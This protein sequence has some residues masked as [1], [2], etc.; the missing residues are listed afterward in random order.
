MEVLAL[1]GVGIMVD[2]PMSTPHTA[3]G[4]VLGFSRA[5]EPIS[6]KHCC[7]LDSGRC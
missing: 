1:V 4:V 7:F 2:F 6:G 5:P 3:L